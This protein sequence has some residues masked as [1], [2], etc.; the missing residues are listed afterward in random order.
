MKRFTVTAILTLLASW[1]AALLAQ[2][3]LLDE[4]QVPIKYY[5]VELIVFTYEENVGVGPTK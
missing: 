1:P 5:T 4:Q 3:E 2:E